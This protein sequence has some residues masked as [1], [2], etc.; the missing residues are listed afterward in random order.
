MLMIP[1]PTLP[2]EVGFFLIMASDRLSLQHGRVKSIDPSCLL[3][4]ATD[5]AV[6]LTCFDR[7]VENSLPKGTPMALILVFRCPVMVVIRLTLKLMNPFELLRNL[8]GMPLTPVLIASPLRVVVVFIDFV[9]R[10]RVSFSCCTSPL[11][12]TYFCR[13]RPRPDWVNWLD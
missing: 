10:I 6:T 13:V 8:Y 9:S 7:M 1:F 11:R 5:E 4:T 3:A 2:S 12:T